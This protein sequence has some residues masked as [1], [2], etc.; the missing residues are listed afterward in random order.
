MATS[1]GRD[2]RMAQLRQFQILALAFTVVA[3]G[4]AGAATPSSSDAEVPAARVPKRIV[5]AVQDNPATLFATTALTVAGGEAPGALY[6]LIRGGLSLIDDHAVLRPELAEVVPS[7]TNGL[8]KVFPGGR[9]E[10][11]WQIREGARWHDGE[12]VTADDFVFT[13][14][15]GQDPD[16]KIA[17]SLVFRQID[18][19]TAPDPR[20]VVVQWKLP[21]VE[22]DA[23]FSRESLPPFAKHIMEPLYASEKQNFMLSPY[24]GPE[25]LGVGPY[26]IREWAQGSYLML[27]ANPDF[28]MGRPNVDE[29]EIRFI[30]EANT[31]L[32]NILAGTVELTLGRSLSLEQGLEV[33][34]Q[35]KDGA[36]GVANSSWV[37]VYP[38]FFNPT[39][40]IVTDV[41]FRKALMFGANR[42]AM[43]DAFLG[44]YSQ[45][46]DGF[47]SPKRPEASA[48]A[49]SVVRY[50]YDPQR[51]AQLLQE[52][53]YSRS[54]DGADTQPLSVPLWT[55]G[56]LDIQTK[57]LFALNDDW[58]T[59]GIASQP[60]VEPL[61]MDRIVRAN[62]PAFEIVRQPNELNVAALLRY[63]GAQSPLPE[64]NYAGTNRTR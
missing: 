56:G 34:K 55:R 12:P 54:S 20:T 41:R 64:N 45:V 19:V 35:W 14:Q 42:Q 8:W 31:L 16:L 3:T 32:T 28:V 53:A 39:P 37:A 17:R 18:S 26:K 1:W 44:G 48:L 52:L 43:V 33:Q 15:V 59:L 38:Q 13:A 36:I 25:F 30:P 10:T 50:P 24:W 63:H 62:Y 11:T 5:A 6:G 61:E 40:P 57:A 46:A 4:C 7:L 29:V 23:L 60:F 51:A 22:A 27:T 21:H 58:S 9:M 47:I 49:N 2:A